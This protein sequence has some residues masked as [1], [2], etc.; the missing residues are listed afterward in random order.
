MDIFPVVAVHIST[1]NDLGQIKVDRISFNRWRKQF[2]GQLV[3]GNFVEVD[4]VAV[5][6]LS[7]SLGDKKYTQ[8]KCEKFDMAHTVVLGW[9]YRKDMGAAIVKLDG[10]LIAT[11][12]LL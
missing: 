9:Q 2:N 5:A 10:W 11:L 4:G 3:V 6:V 12:F 7:K 8:G 1:G